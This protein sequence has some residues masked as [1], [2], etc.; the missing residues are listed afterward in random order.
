MKII[1]SG[2]VHL[3]KYQLIIKANNWQFDSAKEFDGMFFACKT[4]N[5]EI[6]AEHWNSESVKSMTN[7]FAGCTNQNLLHYA[8]KLDISGCQNFSAMFAES[9]CKEDPVNAK[10]YANLVLDIDPHNV[11]ALKYVGGI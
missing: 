4:I 11:E 5:V 8:T 3:L 9:K 2:S 1:S 7:M 6:D 10:K